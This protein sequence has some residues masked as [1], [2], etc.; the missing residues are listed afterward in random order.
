V[1]TAIESQAP[2]EAVAMQ[3]SAPNQEEQHHY[4]P[5]VGLEICISGY[6]SKKKQLGNTVKQFGG[7]YNSELNKLTCNVLVSELPSGLKFK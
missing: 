1:A 5:F 7:R 2:T 6:A 4:G 3:L